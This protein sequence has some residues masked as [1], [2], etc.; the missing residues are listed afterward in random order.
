MLRVT[1]P[2][3]KIH[4]QGLSGQLHSGAGAA[5]CA[6]GRMKPSVFQ[7]ALYHHLR[8]R[9]LFNAAEEINDEATSL[10]YPFE[11]CGGLQECFT[12]EDLETESA[13]AIAAVTF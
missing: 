4:L 2:V 3:I 6:Q 9:R 1:T 10:Q 5:G 13:L 12:L 11:V 8:S 7:G